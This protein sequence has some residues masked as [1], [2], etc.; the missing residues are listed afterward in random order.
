MQEIMRMR[1]IF[2]SVLVFVVSFI[3][4]AQTRVNPVT[5]INW[6]QITGA[7]APSVT[8]AACAAAN[9]GQPYQDTSVTPNTRY[10]CSANGWEL[11][12]SGGTITSGVTATSMTTLLAGDGDYVQPA[13][14]SQVVAR[15]GIHYAA[16]SYPRLSEDSDAYALSRRGSRI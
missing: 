5:Q 12:A 10:H 16:S 1:S 3:G 15:P 7:G 4:S 8:G 2:V 13:T 6:P 11:E 14:S 9:Y